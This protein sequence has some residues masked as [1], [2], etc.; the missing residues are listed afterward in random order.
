MD[1]WVC[2][3]VCSFVPPSPCLSFGK[4]PFYILSAFPWRDSSHCY[5]PEDSKRSRLGQFSFPLSVM[6][7]G[8]V[9][10]SNQA[11]VSF[12]GFVLEVLGKTYC[13]STGLES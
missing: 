3:L 12:S 8:G 7:S 9:C 11:K 13:L 10:D 4:P 5:T 1:T 6:D 2:L